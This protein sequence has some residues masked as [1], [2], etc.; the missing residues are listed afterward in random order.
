MVKALT[1]DPKKCVACKT[2]EVACSL[3]RT[4]R[5]NTSQA[6]IDVVTFDEEGFYCPTACFQCKEAWCVKVCPASAIWI[7]DDLGARVVDEK[8]CVGCRMCTLACPFGNIFVSP[9]GKAKKCDL[10]DG[11]PKCVK[12]CPTQAIKYEPI[13]SSINEKRYRT[14][15]EVMQASKTETESE[16]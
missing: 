14:F 11:D 12:F 10:C 8:K 16:L 15:K 2:C 7:D 1:F 6:R 4:G 3:A 13:D 5:C 9:E